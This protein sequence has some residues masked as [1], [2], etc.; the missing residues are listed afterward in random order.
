MKLILIV[1]IREQHSRKSHVN[2][3]KQKNK[4]TNKLNERTL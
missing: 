2:E 1:M 3:P 4:N